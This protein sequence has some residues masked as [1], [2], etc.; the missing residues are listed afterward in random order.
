MIRIYSKNDELK[1]KNVDIDFKNS[2]MRLGR[3]YSDDISI[4]LKGA[5]GYDTI[6]KIIELKEKVNNTYSVDM[7]F[8]NFFNNETLET[9]TYGRLTM[10]GF[11]FRFENRRG[12]LPEEIFHY[13]IRLVAN[14]RKD[15]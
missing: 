3:E 4:T 2:S 12:V 9:L 14:T 7:H 8:V 1:L 6:K 5:C 11:D 13:E 10:S 15:A